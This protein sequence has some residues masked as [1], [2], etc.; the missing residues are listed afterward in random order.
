[1]ALEKPSQ[2]ISGEVTSSAFS[3]LMAMPL[4]H[5]VAPA[6]GDVLGYGY[7]VTGESKEGD[8]IGLANDN[9]CTGIEGGPGRSE[10]TKEVMGDGASCAVGNA[11]EGSHGVDDAR[12]GRHGVGDDLRRLGSM[13]LGL[14]STTSTLGCKGNASNDL[15]G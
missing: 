12:N 15:C 10:G 8:N 2:A 5:W 7:W 13:R 14:G 11:H 3:M 9:T 6:Y 4:E 1:M